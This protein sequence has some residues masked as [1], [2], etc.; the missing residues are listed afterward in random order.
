MEFFSK[1]FRP[2]ILKVA[3]LGNKRR[4]FWAVIWLFLAMGLWALDIEV[5]YEH[6]VSRGIPADFRS[7]HQHQ[8]YNWRA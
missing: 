6:N 8:V 1:V 5:T 3:M 2:G 7:H 4:V